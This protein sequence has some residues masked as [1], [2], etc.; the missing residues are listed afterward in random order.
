MPGSRPHGWH[1]SVRSYRGRYHTL[2]G[3]SGRRGRLRPPVEVDPSLVEVRRGVEGD[4]ALGDRTVEVLDR[5]EVLVGERLVEHRPEAFGRL[6]LGAVGRQVDEPDALGDGQPGLRVPARVVEDEDDDPVATGPGLAGEE[7]EERLEERLRHPVRQVPEHLARGRLHEGD[8]VEPLEAV[9]A[10]R[11]RALAFRRPDAA[12]D[13][14]QPDAVLVRGEDFDDLA[15]MLLRLFGEDGGEL[16]LNASCSSAVARAGCS[17]RGT[18]TDHPSARSASQPRWTATE[19][20]PSSSA[21][22]AAT[23]RLVPPPTAA[24]WP[25]SHTPPPAAGPASRSRSLSSSSGFR[26]VALVPLRR[27]RSPSA[28]GPPA[29]YRASSFSTHRTP[30]AVVAATSA[31]SWPFASS[32]I[33]WTCRAERASAVTRNRSPSSATLKCPATSATCPPPA[34]QG[35]AYRLRH[36][37]GTVTE[38]ISRKP[39]H[40]HRRPG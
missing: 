2:S 30:N 32:Q 9:G 4:A 1:R 23:L 31:T 37:A 14:L 6:R 35:P 7:G 36:P 10:G 3:C 20:S 11:A 33:A 16:F 28:S 15:R 8:H 40:S 22:H 26:I 21:I 39:Y 17:G 19:A 18:C 24:P 29:L 12:E 27:R 13:R 5:A 34:S 25:L 38:H